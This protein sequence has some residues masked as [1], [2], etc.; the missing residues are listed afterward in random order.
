MTKILRYES[1]QKAGFLEFYQH[2]FVTNISV[3]QE[4]IFLHEGDDGQ[5]YVRNENGSFQQV[6][7]TDDGTYT[8][9]ATSDDQEKESQPR[10]QQN[11]KT[12]EDMYI[13]PDLDHKSNKQVLLH[14]SFIHNSSC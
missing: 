14:I 3:F 11:N 8:I 2:T 6:Y 12:D 9:A 7:M 5:L 1:D 10:S 13:V 4:Q